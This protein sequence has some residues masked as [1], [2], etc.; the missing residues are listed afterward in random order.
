MAWNVWS[1]DTVTGGDRVRVYPSGMPWCRALNGTGQTK[2]ATFLLGDP[3]VSETA[4]RTRLTPL[5]RSLVLDWD[6]HVVYAGRI[7]DRPSYVRSTQTLT[8]THQ[9]I[10]GVF[11]ERFVLSNRS[12]EFPKQG[13]VE[14]RGYGM[15]TIARRLVR[16]SI[17][18]SPTSKY[19]LPIDFAADSPGGSNRKYEGYSLTR[20]DDALGELLDSGHCP[21]MDFRP[22]WD[23]NGKLRYEMRVGGLSTDTLSWQTSGA[24]SEAGD[25]LTD[26]EIL[27]SSDNLA[28]TVFGVGQGSGE[29]MKAK[30]AQSTS[31][32]FPA[33]EV[34]VSSKGKEDDAGLQSQVDEVLRLGQAPTEQHRLTMRVD[35][36]PGIRDLQVGMTA[37]IYYSGDPWIPDGWA[38]T[39]LIQYSGDLTGAVKLDFQPVDG[40]A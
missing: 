20:L 29:D 19:G 3:K 8:V 21:D 27:E 4:T 14:H 22:Y 25:A 31:S 34:Q 40:G 33:R 17:N 11:S 15:G 18:T 35:G 2:Q 12:D 23:S 36:S 7:K 9:D 37:R 24:L 1:V 13:K 6:G 10:W 30:V 38:T 16:D 26:V 39:R 32:P 28:S 5:V